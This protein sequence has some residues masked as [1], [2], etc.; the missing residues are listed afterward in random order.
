MMYTFTMTWQKKEGCVMNILRSNDVKRINKIVIRKALLEL[1]SA[2][3]KE[4]MEVTG[5]SSS[6]IG[7]LIMEMVMENDILE[8]SI[9]TSSG[10]RC[11]MRYVLNY[12]QYRI[13]CIL[14]DREELQIYILDSLHQ[15]V[16]KN[17]LSTHDKEIVLNQVTQLCKDYDV[18]SINVST[19]GIVNDA[20][21]IQDSTD[22]LRENTLFQ[23]MREASGLAMYIENDVK[24][25]VQGYYNEHELVDQN[26]SYLYLSSE[27]G[28][29]CASMAEGII[30][31]G[32][33]HLA[34]EI[35]LLEYYGHSMNNILRQH[36][37]EMTTIQILA[38]LISVLVC[39][40]NPSCIVLSGID[41]SYEIKLKAL[42]QEIV[43]ERFSL[44][45]VFDS[46]NE[47]HMRKALWA[48]A[49][50][51]MMHDEQLSLI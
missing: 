6:S 47:H 11:P 29:G 51:A 26:L 18:K 9:D 7:S 46:D 16:Y 32:S 39:S 49:M 17:T 19:P 2:T 35:G 10:G 31:R 48:N 43:S 38:R 23:E 34:G 30:I 28:L 12:E 22:G 33:D 40:I 36:P 3:R 42:V 20:L 25:M 8:E 24:C 13:M 1:R 44:N 45:L 4:L 41:P 37:D 5:I 14:A 27:G 15:E 21:V 50:D